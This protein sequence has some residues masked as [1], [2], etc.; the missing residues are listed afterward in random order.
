MRPRARRGLQLAG[1]GLWRGVSLVAGMALHI[2]G[3]A[4][5]EPV[6]PVA[7]GEPEGGQGGVFIAPEEVSGLENVVVLDVRGRVAFRGAHLPRAVRAPWDAFVEG[8]FLDGRLA[9]VERVGA[10]LRALGVEDDATV[11]VYGEWDRGWG[12]EGRLYWMLDYLGHD[13]VRIL[14]G[15]YPRWQALGLPLH[16]GGEETPAP[17][18]FVPKPQ[19]TRRAVVGDVQ[20]HMESHQ[21]LLDVRADEEWEGSRRYGVERGGRIP[22][23]THWH[24]RRAFD[25]QSDLRPPDELRAELASIGVEADRE[26]VTYCT[27]GVRAGFV[28]AVLRWLGFTSIRNYEASFWEWSGRGDLPVVLPPR[29]P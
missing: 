13:D 17:G 11:V 26:V 9:D 24:W 8:L 28:Y 15:G 10:Q 2:G 16:A 29:R 5:D 25:A 6:G 12:E 20:R 18:R 19:A 7:R 1:Q 14:Y 3:C 4:A 23:A 22:T 27:G 21:G